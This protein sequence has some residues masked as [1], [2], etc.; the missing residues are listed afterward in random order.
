MVNLLLTG[1][2]ISNTFDDVIELDSG[3]EEKVLFLL[4]LRSFT[5]SLL[6]IVIFFAEY[7]EGR[8]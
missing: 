6:L 3:G 5:F 1:K 8:G 4:Q 2:A 7:P